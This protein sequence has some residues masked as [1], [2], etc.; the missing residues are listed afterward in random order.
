[1][2]VISCAYS[3]EADEE[4]G[5]QTVLYPT[6]AKARKGA[7]ELMRETRENILT[8]LEKY[9]T[10][11]EVEVDELSAELSEVTLPPLTRDAVCAI[12]NT[13]GGSYVTSER[14]LLKITLAPG[15]KHPTITKLRA[16][17]SLRGA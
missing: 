8:N 12:I 10:L 1:M 3:F 13:C 5:G 14:P 9:G 11:D 6:L 7:I 2:K 4:S 17:T 15:K 16:H